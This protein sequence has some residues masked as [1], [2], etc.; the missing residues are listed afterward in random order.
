MTEELGVTSFWGFSPSKDLLDAT[1]KFNEA[2]NLE[3]PETI[4]ILLV[5]PADIRHI[6]HTMAKHDDI[7]INVSSPA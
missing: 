1:L 2:S 3:K 6:M 5:N 4:N 7:F